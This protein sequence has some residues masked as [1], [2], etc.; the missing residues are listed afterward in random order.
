MTDQSDEQL[1][2]IVEQIEAGN[3]EKADA[4]ERVKELYAHAG[5]SG[6]DVKVLRRIIALRKRDRDELAEAEA[7]EHVYR[8]AL[9]MV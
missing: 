4:A 3:A 9:G 8:Q 2:Q 7:V 1:R 6:Y 5:S